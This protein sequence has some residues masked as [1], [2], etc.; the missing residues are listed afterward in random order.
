MSNEPLTRNSSTKY[1]DNTP[2][3]LAL[4]AMKQMEGGEREK[5]AIEFYRNQI[6]PLF[7]ET[8]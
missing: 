6:L 3:Y 5:A 7:R 4:E 8:K 2:Y 1:I